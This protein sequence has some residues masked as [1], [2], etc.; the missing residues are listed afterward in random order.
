MCMCVRVC[1]L[2]LKAGVSCRYHC[3]L[4][5]DHRCHLHLMV[6]LW[7]VYVYLQAL[8]LL[9]LLLGVVEQRT[10]KTLG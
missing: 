3:G 8:S 4:I 7:T 9:H 2:G 6:L 5:E 1:E 10:G